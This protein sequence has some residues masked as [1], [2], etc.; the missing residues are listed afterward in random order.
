M[1]QATTGT[2]AAIA[3]VAAP[4][5]TMYAGAMLLN[6]ALLAVLPGIGSGTFTPTLA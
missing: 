4:L 1:G 5:P 6:D 2:R 3:R